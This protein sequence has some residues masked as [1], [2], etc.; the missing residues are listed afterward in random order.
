[1][2]ITLITGTPGAGKTLFAV[3]LLIDELLPQGR[4]LWHNIE[5]LDA[6]ALGEK[7]SEDAPALV[8]RMV[9]F[10]PRSWMEAE[11]GAIFIFDECQQQFPARNPASKVPAHISPLET[12]RHRG[13]DFVFVTQHPSMLDSHVKSLCDKH[14]HLYR[15]FGFERSTHFQ[16]SGVNPSPQPAQNRENAETRNFSFPKEIY[17]VYKSASAHTVNK[18]IPWRLLVVFGALVVAIIVVGFLFYGFIQ[19]FTGQSTETQDPTSATE[20]AENLSSQPVCYPVV[21]K[22]EERAV[23]RLDGALLFIPASALG[24]TS[25]RYCP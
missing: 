4:V 22:A 17:E 20:S 10:D 12:H 8:R 18:R 9:D 1:M 25:E 14:H 19:R 11:D 16:W 23:Y 7:F 3:K 15:P 2:P 6:D 24:P 21:M 13:F 5:G